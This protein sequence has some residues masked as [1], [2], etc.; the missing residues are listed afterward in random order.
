MPKSDPQ[1]QIALRAL[2]FQEDPFTRSADPRFLYLSE[3]HGKVVDRAQEVIDNFRGL[4]VVEGGFGVGKSTIAR[5]LENI[6]RGYTDEATV[7]FS[8]TTSYETEYAGLVDICFGFGLPRLKGL[9]R[10][11]RSFEN[12][13]I[14]ERKTGRN[15]LVIL[16]DAQLMRPDALQIVHHVYNF[17][18][19]RKLAQIVLFGQPEIK[20]MFALHPEIRSRVDSW[21]TLEALSLEDT[22]RLIGFRCTVAGRESPILTQAGVIS[23]YGVTKGVPRDIVDLCS[24]IIDLMGRQG[25]YET[26]SE[27]TINEAIAEFQGRRQAM[28]RAEEHAFVP[29]DEREDSDT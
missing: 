16:D 28:V 5:R 11:W 13:L 15:V 23:V 1:R 17:D 21:F 4:A 26:A 25:E 7:L 20:Y 6:Y 12:F 24:K 3:Q 9:T 8:H 19:Q 18:V 27:P 22:A 29:Q 14:S 2:G 10:Q